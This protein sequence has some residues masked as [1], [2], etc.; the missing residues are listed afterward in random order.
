MSRHF[1][2]CWEIDE[3]ADTPL[4]AIRQAIAAFPHAGNPDSLATIFDV[5]ELDE[6][7]QVVRLHSIDLEEEDEEG[8]N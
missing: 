8:G 3:F 1:L 4:E 2:V 6:C 7:G 5:R